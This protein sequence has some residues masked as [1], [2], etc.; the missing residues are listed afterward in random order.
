MMAHHFG[1]SCHHQLNVARVREEALASAMGIGVCVGGVSV[2][3][4]LIS[5]GGF[6]RIQLLSHNPIALKSNRRLGCLCEKNKKIMKS[7]DVEREIC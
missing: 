3:N 2:I 1:I 6:E 4:V 5:D 7:N